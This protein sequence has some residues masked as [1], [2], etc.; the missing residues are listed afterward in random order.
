MDEYELENETPYDLNEIQELQMKRKLH[1]QAIR[2]YQLELA[3]I[4]KQIE[5]LQNSDRG[6]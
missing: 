3:S 1:L 6:H 5:A 2:R 4:E